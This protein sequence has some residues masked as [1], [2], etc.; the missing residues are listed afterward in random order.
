MSISLQVLETI[1][2]IYFSDAESFDPSEYELKVKVMFINKRHSLLLL[3]IDNS[4]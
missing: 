3:R 2:E 1:E 4:S